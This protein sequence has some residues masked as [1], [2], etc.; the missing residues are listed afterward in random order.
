ML[1]YLI[2]TSHLWNTISSWRPSKA[3]LF[4]DFCWLLCRN[5]SLKMSPDLTHNL[6]HLREED[7]KWTR[8]TDLILRSTRLLQEKTYYHH[9]FN[10]CA[11]FKH[12]VIVGNLGKYRVI[13]MYVAYTSALT[14][15][16]TLSRWW[17]WQLHRF[18]KVKLW[19]ASDLRLYCSLSLQFLPVLVIFFMF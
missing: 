18:P 14:T 16:A 13:G 8:F 5:S 10:F 11:F 15:F 7:W 19:I 4:S 2:E 6:G 9:Y 1:I 3:V 17:I 12:H